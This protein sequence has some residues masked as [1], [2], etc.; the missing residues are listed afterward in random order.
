MLKWG[1][2]RARLYWEANAP[3]RLAFPTENSGVG[4]VERFI[5][6]KYELG[7]W[8]AEEY[9]PSDVEDLPD[10]GRHRG[11][12]VKKSKKSKKS[13]SAAPP[14]P[15]TQA[16]APAAAAPAPAPAVSAVTDSFD[17]LGF[18]SVPANPSS[19]MVAAPA[20][21]LGGWP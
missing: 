16:A 18:D 2:K 5:R 11:A 20:P 3:D 8:K 21:V 15:V 17:L 10:V 14:A 13:K 4:E 6:D 7:K 9:P 1:N 12:K 19:P